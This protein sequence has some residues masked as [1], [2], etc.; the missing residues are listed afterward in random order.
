MGGRKKILK[1]P[2]ILMGMFLL[3]RKVECGAETDSG[4]G[5]EVLREI[6]LCDGAE[7]DRKP[8]AP[9]LLWQEKR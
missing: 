8:L 1:L 3:N 9:L 2:H 6:T 4:G 7:Y 5:S